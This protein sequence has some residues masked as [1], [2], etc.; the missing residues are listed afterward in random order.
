MNDLLNQI[1]ICIERGKVSAQSPHPADMKGLAGAI[2]LTKEAL[3]NKIPAKDILDNGLLK[4]MQRVGE[5]FR[6]GKIFI[7]EVL[8]SAKAMNSAMELLKP[9]FLSGEI[10]LK[11][12]VI[13]GTVTGDL[14]DIGK[15]ILR[16]VLEGGG[17]QVIDLGVNVNADKF[18][19][20]IKEH[21]AK[22]IGLSALLTTTMQNMEAIVKSI[23]VIFDDVVIVVGGAPLN[24]E[25]ADKISA[26]AYFPA[27]Q[28]MLD[29]IDNLFNNSN[30]SYE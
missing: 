28:G 19:N 11:G 12:K 5:K 20:S 9:Y 10:N 29:Y 22:I 4:G 26:D 18:I 3:N 2:E 6:D 8:I 25:F 7:P 15:N 1:S 21:N 23:K 30:H 27:P 13:L 16:M 17:W 14:H 24:R